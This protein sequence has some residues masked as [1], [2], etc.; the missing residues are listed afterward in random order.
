MTDW[1]R[2]SA[3]LALCALAALG[4]ASSAW[5]ATL[6]IGQPYVWTEVQEVPV[7]GWAGIPGAQVI[8]M[9][10]DGLALDVHGSVYVAVPSRFAV[11]RINTEDLTQEMIAIFDSDPNAPHFAPL[12][13]PNSMAFGT[14]KGGRQNLF[15]GNMGVAKAT[16]GPPSLGYSLTRIEAGVP[17]LPLP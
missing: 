6:T 13:F 15:I 2:S 9:F 17:G 5:A 12:D 4:S 8:A 10:L 11:V 16:S 7:S 3:I 1:V 14:G